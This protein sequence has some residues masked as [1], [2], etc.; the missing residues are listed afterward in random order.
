MTPHR[1]VAARLFVGFGIVILVFAGAI[2][3]SLYR[4]SGFNAEVSLV[5]GPELA[6]LQAADTWAFEISNGMRHMRNM[7]LLDDKAHLQEEMDAV[8]AAAGKRKE[9]ADFMVAKVDTAE[10]KAL[11]QS[12]LELRE[13]NLPLEQEFMRQFEAGQLKDARDTLMVRARPTQRASMDSLTKLADYQK[14]LIKQKANALSAAYSTAR[15]FILTL[16]LVAIVAACGIAFLITRAIRK[17]LS[18]AVDVLAE[19]ERGNYDNVVTVSSGDETGT[20]LTALDKMQKT[21]K[22]RIE[23]E[24]TLA[25]E[26]ERTKVALD[27]VASNV[28]V[29]D[30]DGKIVYMNEAVTAMFRANAG[31]IRKQ[32]PQFDADRVLGSNFDGF[33]RSPSHQRNMLASLQGTHTT[34]IKLGTAVLRIIGSPVIDKTGAR[35]GTVVQ[36]VDRSTEVATEEEINVVVKAAGEGDLT[37]RVRTDGKSGFFSVLATGINAILAKSPAVPTRSHEATRT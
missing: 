35:L 21:L 23:R 4:L 29:A 3:L 34:D 32:L 9:L 7:L 19:I 8:R 22:E 24:R 5:T 11:L 33:H 10:G 28:M 37:Q 20:V 25:A 6:K 15:T 36:W 14:E 27:K 12:V 13:K 26:N 31:E 1:S 30:T 18:Q 2:A 17:P 16:A